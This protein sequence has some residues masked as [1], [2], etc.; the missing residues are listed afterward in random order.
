MAGFYGRLQQG[1]PAGSALRQAQLDLLQ[2]G[3]PPYVW[4]PFQLVGDGEWGIEGD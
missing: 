1:A 3:V 4:A 2:S